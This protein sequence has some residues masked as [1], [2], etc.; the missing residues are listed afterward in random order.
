MEDAQ[1]FEREAP[2][3][4]YRPIADLGQGGS[5]SVFLG[6]ARGPNAFNKLVV[7][8]M[9][10]RELAEDSDSRTMFLTEARL[11]ARLNHPNVVQTN[12]V[13][14]VDGRPIMVMEY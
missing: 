8:K 14:E 13:L 3:G 5:A 1:K 11:S 7:L 4:K 10:K 2:A 9:L 6:V 12:E